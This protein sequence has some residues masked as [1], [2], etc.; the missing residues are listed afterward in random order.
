ML[1]AVPAKI[2][3]ESAGPITNQF[4]SLADWHQPVPVMVVPMARDT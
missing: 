1:K 4:M 2:K 3:F